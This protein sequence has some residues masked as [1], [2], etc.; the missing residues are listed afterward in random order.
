MLCGDIGCYTLGN[1]EPLDAVD[2]CLCMGAGITMAQGFAVAEPHKK[3]V[4]FVGDS[5]FFASGMTGI[6]NAVYN[7]HDVTFSILDNATTAMTGTQP[8]PGTGVTLMGP[9]RR[10]HR[11]RARA[12]GLGFECIGFA[13]PHDL[14]GSVAAVGEAIDF[15]GPSAVIFRVP[16]HPA[17]EARRA[18]GHGCRYVH[19]LQEVHHLDRLSRHRLRR[20][21]ARPEEQ[22]SAARLSWMR[23]C[24]TAAACAPRCAPSTPGRVGF[25]WS[26]ADTPDPSRSKP[27]DRAHSETDG[28]GGRRPHA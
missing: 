11:D 14:E 12:A 19:G 28:C 7:G 17:D 10:A 4:A 24:A 1:A 21:R 3:H 16:V 15:E 9:K 8:H 27:A 2:T 13:N 20:G 5:T 23:A 18:R 6:V 26:V 22:A 25:G